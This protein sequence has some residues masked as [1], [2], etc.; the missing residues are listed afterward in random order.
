M[1]ERLIYLEVDSPQCQNS[2]KLIVSCSVDNV[3][4][5]LLTGLLVWVSV[6]VS[7]SHP[8]VDM[9]DFDVWPLRAFVG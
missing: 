2:Q 5:F 4:V 7:L 8:S 6:T 3:H 1:S 9:C